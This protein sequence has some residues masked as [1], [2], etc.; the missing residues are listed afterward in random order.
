V[1]AL[2]GLLSWGGPLFSSN[3]TRKRTMFSSR[4]VYVLRPLHLSD[5]AELQTMRWYV[6]SFPDG[7]FELR[8][9]KCANAAITVYGPKHERSR[10]LYDLCLLECRRVMYDRLPSR[11][12]MPGRLHGTREAWMAHYAHLLSSIEFTKFAT[13]TKNLSPFVVVLIDPHSRRL[14]RNPTI[15][16]QNLLWVLNG[17]PA[18]VPLFV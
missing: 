7:A 14:D 5:P 4:N 1:G 18:A 15:G 10:E 12:A 13:L 8:R 9:H 11:P 17:H 3:L 6:T 2:Q 16:R